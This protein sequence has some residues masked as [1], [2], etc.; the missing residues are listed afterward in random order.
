[1]PP[2]H[3]VLVNARIAVPTAA[4]FAALAKS[5]AGAAPASI[6][7]DPVS[8]LVESGGKPNADNL[9][10]ALASSANDLEA[11]ATALFAPVAETLAALHATRR[12][13]LARMSGSGGTCFGLFANAHDARQAASRLARDHPDWWVR[14]ATLGSA[15]AMPVGVSLLPGEDR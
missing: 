10:D 4:V 1:V 3:A 15:S 6:D 2:L 9:I 8:R 14:A 5:R 12:C 13:R 11:P 7:G